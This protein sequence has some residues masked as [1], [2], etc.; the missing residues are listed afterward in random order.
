ML[1]LKRYQQRTLEALKDYFV[2]CRKMNDADIAFYQTTQKWWGR[3]I[4]YNNIQELP[5]L[6]YVCL[7]IPTG[8]GKTLIACSAAGIAQRELLGTERNIILWLVP[9][10]AIREQ[11]ITALR[12]RHHPYRQ[13]LEAGVG[14]VE[15]MDISQALY[16]QSSVA[17]GQ[18]VVI[19]STMQ[20]FRVDE[21]EGRKVYD[22]SGHLK[23]HFDNIKPQQAVNL[24]CYEDSNKPI[25]SLANVL[26]LHRPIVIVD[27]AHNA[28]TELSFT[29]LARFAPSCII[30]FSATP[31]LEKQPSNVLYRATAAELKAEEMIKIPIRLETRWEWKQLLADA[32]GIRNGLEK[33][34]QMEQQETGEYIRPV[35]LLQ[36]Q[37]KRKGK[38]T[39][40]PELLKQTLIDD[41]LIPE[42]QIAI[43]TGST[44]ELDGVEISEKDCPL[45]Y[46]ITV[47]ALR[48]GWDCPFAYV[49]FTVAENYSSRA[50]EQILGRVLRMPQA[51]TKQNEELNYAYAYASA[52]E[53]PKV[54]ASLT[55]ALVQNGFNRLEAKDLIKPQSQDDSTLFDDWSENSLFANKVTVEIPDMPEDIRLTGDVK[56]YVSIDKK[57]N[58]ITITGVMPEKI[59][60]KFKKIF[61]SKKAKDAVETA[62]Q[63]TIA[64]QQQS[65]KIRRLPS[66]R[67]PN[68]AIYTGTF[69]E[70]FEQTHFLEHEWS[71]SAC[72][73]LL[74]E[75][76]YSIARSEGKVGEID[77]TEDG[78]VFYEYLKNLW[79][80]VKNLENN[81][82]WTE[83]DLVFWL[84]N[85]IQ[86]RD[87]TPTEFRNFL[88]KSVLALTDK[89]CFNVSQIV[90]EKIRFR[91]AIEDKV[92]KYRQDA[93]KEAFQTLL[94]AGN[95]KVETS[96]ECC[97]EYD[98]NKYPYSSLYRGPHRFK[99]HYYPQ[100]GDLKDKGEEFECAVFLDQLPEVECWIRNLERREDT[101]FWFQTSTDKFYPDFVCQ[102][103]D[104][105]YLIVEYKGLDR[106]SND[107]SKEKRIIGEVWEKRSNGKCLFIMPKGTNLKEI[108]QKIN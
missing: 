30:E 28:R 19:V 60:D 100:V 59:K 48:E 20:A 69:W 87:I 27:E 105:R 47:E 94:F 45:R 41:H 11:T 85:N 91:D 25:P 15:I 72:N 37:K 84:D 68:L 22:Q 17:S 5:G 3:G 18:T 23:H 64:R 77:V 55:D 66:F 75:E 81:D 6:P 10:N 106:W 40:S 67:I 95:S 78:S 83:A 96:P 90:I 33:S 62:H 21:T 104:G 74:T 54:A 7:R 51:K 34:A 108:N 26:K 99:K 14:P 57:D 29:T 31:D 79:D 76:E 53:W 16:L 61:H 43:A 38:E 46:V 63:Q 36:A 93:N 88:V 107:D 58:S 103:K 42:N 89:R 65:N 92:N 9:S 101:S 49:L 1:Q 8:G 82:S 39:I 4:P 44:K 32:V 2:A 50:V 13:E 98:I 102:L 35:M 70:Q 12:D 80:D 24:E 71:L 73:A 56:E 86:H 52:T 97:F